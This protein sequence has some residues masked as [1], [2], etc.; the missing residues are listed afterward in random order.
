MKDSQKVGS[1]GA[2]LLALMFVL[3]LAYNVYIQVVGGSVGPANFDPAKVFAPSYTVQMGT[4]YVLNLGFALGVALL[5]LGIGDRLRQASPGLTLVF[6]AAGLAAAILFWASG[7]MGLY[8]M[9][10][11]ASAYFEDPSTGIALRGVINV[12]NGLSETAQSVVGWC[13]LLIGWA[14][15][16]TEVFSKRL[17]YVSA[18]LGVIW[19]ISFIV[20]DLL[21]PIATVISIVWAF[22]WRRALLQ[23]PAKLRESSAV[24]G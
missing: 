4:P 7:V 6:V 8:M 24:A 3:I 19:I 17:G 11:L 2:L 9:P 18:L 5:V 12:P 15:V 1:A 14:S 10:R 13:L 23:E 21:A 16:R 22:W 20:P